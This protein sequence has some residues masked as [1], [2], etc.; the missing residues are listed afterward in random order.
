LDFF[1]GS[2]GVGNG[3]PLL[4][5]F[6]PLARRCFVVVALST[7]YYF[8]AW[9]LPCAPTG[10]PLLSRKSQNHSSDQSCCHREMPNAMLFELELQFRTFVYSFIYLLAVQ[11]AGFGNRRRFVVAAGAEA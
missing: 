5:S 2:S 9:P 4:S 3:E 10:T 7:V 1:L 6:A 11:H 8:G